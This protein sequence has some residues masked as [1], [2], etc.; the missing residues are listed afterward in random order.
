M[1]HSSA[2]GFG[3]TLLSF[4]SFSEFF[5]SP[6]WDMAM[7]KKFWSLVRGTYPKLQ[8]CFTTQNKVD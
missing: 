6:Y 7:T 3:V 4:E 5:I 8:S 1:V 2:N